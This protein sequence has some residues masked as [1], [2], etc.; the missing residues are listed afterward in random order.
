MTFA[1]NRRWF[2][3][4]L[5]AMLAGLTAL[6]IALAWT[7]NWAEQRKAFRRTS[8]ALLGPVVPTVVGYGGAAPFPLSL[9]GQEGVSLLS[10]GF[11]GELGARLSAEQQAEL[12][13]IRRLF[14]EAEVEGYIYRA[15]GKN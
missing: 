9:M 5:A 2:R 1:P 10:V 13:R 6:G 4:S 3:F 11:E 7:R 12:H 8:P 14:P 15:I